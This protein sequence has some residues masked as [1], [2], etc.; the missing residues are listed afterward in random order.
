M[1]LFVGDQPYRLVIGF[2]LSI[3]SQQQL[4]HFQGICLCG[5]VK[6]GAVLHFTS[7]H[8][9]VTASRS[10]GTFGT[11]QDAGWHVAGAMQVL[12]PYIGQHALTE[13]KRLPIFVLDLERSG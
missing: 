10:F 12:N 9:Q 6:R 1:H 4:S 2:P 5:Q 3:V 8:L 7:Y 11:S 13:L